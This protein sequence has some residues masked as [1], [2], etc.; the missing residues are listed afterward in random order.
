VYPN[1]TTGQ[2][3]IRIV[4]E[5]N[6]EYTINVRDAVGRLVMQSTMEVNN[7]TKNMMMN[8]G[9]LA[10]GT[11]SVEVLGYYQTQTFKIQLSK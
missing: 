7:T 9:G 1:P 10:A 3:N 11:Y 4:S 2:L 8:L 5:Q 6:D